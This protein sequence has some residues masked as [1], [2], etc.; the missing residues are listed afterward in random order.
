MIYIVFELAFVD[1]MI[2][3]LS[4]SL[5]ATIWANLSDDELVV[6]ALAELETLINW[7]AGVLDDFFKLKRSK[8]TP[9]VLN[10]LESCAW[11]IIVISEST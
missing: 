6:L 9:F 8:I 10:C 5:N 7:R 3:L 11:L 1:Y 2:D 4:N